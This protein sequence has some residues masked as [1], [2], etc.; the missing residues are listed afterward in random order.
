[1]MKTVKSCVAQPDRKS[2]VTKQAI[3]YTFSKKKRRR[4]EVGS[5]IMPAMKIERINRTGR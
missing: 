5:L 1:M 2:E 4:K 3:K